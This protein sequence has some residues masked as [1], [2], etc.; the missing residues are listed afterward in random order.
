VARLKEALAL[1]DSECLAS[2]RPESLKRKYR[3]LRTKIEA[4]IELKT[5]AEL[6]RVSLILRQAKRLIE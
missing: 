2:N 5:N 6:K 1:V 4:E 3:E